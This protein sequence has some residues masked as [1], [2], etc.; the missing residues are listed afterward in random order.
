MTARRARC[1][2]RTSAPSSSTVTK[3]P[4]IGTLPGLPPTPVRAGRVQPPRVMLRYV[5]LELR[6][7]LVSSL[8]T[9]T[10]D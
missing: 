8:L 7:R 5:N 10:L 2:T 4:N 3:V 6:P 1:G 9:P